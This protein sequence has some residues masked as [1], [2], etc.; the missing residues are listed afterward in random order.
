MKNIQTGKTDMKIKEITTLDGISWSDG[1]DRWD[2]CDCGI[3]LEEARACRTWDDL[4]K[5]GCPDGDIYNEGELSGKRGPLTIHVSNADWDV[6]GSHTITIGDPVPECE[7]EPEWDYGA[8][9]VWPVHDGS[10]STVADEDD[11]PTEGD[12]GHAWRS[13]H[14]LVGG[15]KE[16]PGVFGSGGGVTIHEVCVRCGL[17]RHTDTWDQSWTGTGEPVET[18]RYE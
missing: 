18:V 9:E 6:M 1:T 11:L 5:L 8:D 7:P 14:A 13:P 17:H 16:N 15:L 2:A 12:E 4:A 3:T 10:G